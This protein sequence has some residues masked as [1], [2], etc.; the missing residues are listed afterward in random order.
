MP[1]LIASISARSSSFNIERPYKYC[2]SEKVR[3]YVTPFDSSDTAI[4]VLEVSG[5][6]VELRELSHNFVIYDNV[7]MFRQQTNSTPM[8]LTLALRMIEQS[9]LVRIIRSAQ[10]PELCFGQCDLAL[11]VLL[12]VVI[13][14]HNSDNSAYMLDTSQTYRSS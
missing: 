7:S 5:H 13:H 11:E 9:R 8:E 2:D 3:P 4:G 14:T 1:L 6:H 12:T 10:F